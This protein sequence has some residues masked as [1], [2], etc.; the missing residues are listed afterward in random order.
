MPEHAGGVDMTDVEHELEVRVVNVVEEFDR[1]GRLDEDLARLELPQ[2]LHAGL[3]AA[4]GVLLEGRHHPVPSP[5]VVGVA[6]QRP[7]VAGV[8][9]HLR[10]AAI[11]AELETVVEKLLI[12]GQCV[13]SPGRPCVLAEVAVGPGRVPDDL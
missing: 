2:H 12:P 13:V 5:V 6:G 3:A 9:S 10:D 4:L 1:L 8:D 7:E 11:D